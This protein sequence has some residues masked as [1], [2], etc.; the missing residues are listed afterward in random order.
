MRITTSAAGKAVGIRL[1]V[2]ACFKGTTV[3]FA[4]EDYGLISAGRV[5]LSK[6][7]RKVTVM[8]LL[9]FSA[10][11]LH[12]ASLPTN[13]LIYQPL[14]NSREIRLVKI[15]PGNRRTKV[16]CVLEPASLDH[17][18]P[19]YDALSYCWGDA[20]QKTWVTCNEQHLEITKD[21]FTAIHRFRHKD[22]T[23]RIWIDQFCIDQ[24]NLE[25]RGNQ[26]QLMRDIYSRARNTLVWLGG[27]ADQSVLAFKLM[28]RLREPLKDCMSASIGYNDILTELNSNW[29]ATEWKAMAGLLQRP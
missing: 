21:L 17:D 20:S 9:S 14:Q 13:K 27:K 2:G 23:I 19:G 16:R 29:D 22:Q 25:E 28:E 24:K 4:L 3:L 10:G 11:S 26:V 18:L 15:L 12:L 8:K 5:G 7:L 6:T 1:N